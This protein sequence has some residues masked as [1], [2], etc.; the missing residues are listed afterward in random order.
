[1]YTIWP[2]RLITKREEMMQDQ[3]C[4]ELEKTISDLPVHELHSKEEFEDWNRR[5]MN[6]SNRIK[7]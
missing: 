3:A 2:R 4:K 1:M 6:G 7:R 5:Q